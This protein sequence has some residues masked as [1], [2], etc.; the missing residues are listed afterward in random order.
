MKEVKTYEFECNWCHKTEQTTVA[1][2]H[3]DELVDRNIEEKFLA[4][5]EWIH[6]RIPNQGEGKSYFFFCSLKCFGKRMLRNLDTMLDAPIHR[7]TYQ[8][9]YCE[10][11]ELLFGAII[12]ALKEDLH[13]RREEYDKT[14]GKKEKDNE[15]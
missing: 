15:E 9:N 14:Y 10:A 11:H 4:E 6:S 13:A 2:Y 3:C 5:N 8:T 1:R 7:L 12:D